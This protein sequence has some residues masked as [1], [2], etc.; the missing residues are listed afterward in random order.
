MKNGK[1]RSIVFPEGWILDLPEYFNGVLDADTTKLLL[2]TC[3]QCKHGAVSG[4]D[5]SY[6]KGKC[7]LHNDKDPART[8]KAPLLPPPAQPNDR[9]DK[10]IDK[11]PDAASKGA[12]NPDPDS[13][14]VLEGTTDSN[15]DN[16]FLYW[17]GLVAVLG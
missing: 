1:G 12:P 8:G 15:I 7:R 4:H 5:H 6:E 2:W 14:Q 13:K 10:F 11:P 3:P 16:V 17:P 9:A